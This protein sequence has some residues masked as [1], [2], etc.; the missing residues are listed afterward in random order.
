MNN[1]LL[2][3]KKLKSNTPSAKKSKPS[4]LTRSD[5]KKITTKQ[6]KF[7]T[8]STKRYSDERFSNSTT[9]PKLAETT[10][11]RNTVD[12]NKFNKIL[13]HKDHLDLKNSPSIT[14][15]K[16]PKQSEHLNFEDIKFEIFQISNNI[17][18]YLNYDV[19]RSITSEE[20]NDIDE[21]IVLCLDDNIF[22]YEHDELS[23]NV[24]GIDY[25]KSRNRKLNIS[26]ISDGLEIFGEMKSDSD[27]CS[28]IDEV[29]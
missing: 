21:N 9:D 11:N 19:A 7:P 26:I 5:F 3:P 27:Y 12:I 29:G 2:Q 17:S 23:M 8:K 20:I 14:S 16:K 4:N 22:E 18:S 15:F 6:I 28:G 1:A 13:N 24:S 25:T 10:I